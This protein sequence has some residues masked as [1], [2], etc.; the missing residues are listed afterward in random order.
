MLK[1]I[2]LVTIIIV[3]IGLL[4]DKL[5]TW[6]ENKYNETDVS[7]CRTWQESSLRYAVTVLSYF[8][9]VYLYFKWQHPE[10]LD[11]YL[12]QLNSL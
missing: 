9:L 10:L 2:I 12:S 6:A 4:V 1:Y 8:G 11:Q 5:V 7:D 3:C